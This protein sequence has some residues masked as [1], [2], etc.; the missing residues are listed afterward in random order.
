MRCTLIY[1][2]NFA[3]LDQVSIAPGERNVVK[4]A[5]MNRQGKSSLMNA[6]SAALGGA[7]EEPDEPVRRGKKKAEIVVRLE[8]KELE[9]QLEVKKR[10]RT[11]GKKTTSSLEVRDKSGKLSSPQAILDKLVGKRFLDPLQFTRLSEKQ[12]REVLLDCVDL[13]IDL[14]EHAKQRK[15]A[16]Q[17]R[18]DANRDV[19]RLKT[20]LA[21]TPAPKKL[22]DHA[23]PDELLAKLEQLTE[24]DQAKVTAQHN[25]QTMLADAKQKKASIS[26]AE[27]LLE[28]EK[29]ELKSIIDLHEVALRDQQVAIED[30][31]ERIKAR[32]KAYEKFVKD[33]KAA[34]AK[35]EK[36]AEVDLSEEIE[37]TKEAIKEA[38]SSNA[39]RAKLNAQKESHDRIAK[40]LKEAEKEAEA[41]NAEIEELDDKQVTAL[42]EAN[43]PIDNLDIDEERVLYNDI[44]LSQASGAEQLQVSLAIAASLSPRLRDIWVKDGALLDESS[45]DLVQKFAEDNDLCIWLERVGES[46]D[47]CI[48]IEEGVVKV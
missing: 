43:M 26:Q 22:P 45:M 6:F 34:R 44:P 11:D 23:S 21:A 1:A 40:S 16:F 33:G 27:Q 39:E 3:A 31:E 41:Y 7:K 29:A 32:E 28:Q 15:E 20:E 18:A 10:F 8:D 13:S 37:S 25:L 19:K 12:Q 30:A 2:K 9:E 36:L 42:A 17:N 4:V 5:G 47:D 48:I 46:D 35:A 38:T 24:Q 14:N